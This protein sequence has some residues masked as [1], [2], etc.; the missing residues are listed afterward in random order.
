MI[1]E[2]SASLGALAERLGDEATEADARECLDNLIAAG[3]GGWD[4]ID[5]P[6]DTFLAAASGPVEGPDEE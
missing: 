3:W 1:I 5:I 2:N 6:S 4:S